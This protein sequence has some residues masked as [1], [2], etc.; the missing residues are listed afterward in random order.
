M[1]EDEYV[2]DAGQWSEPYGVAEGAPTYQPAAQLP[3][4]PLA[5]QP[6]AQP[7]MQARPAPPPL[8]APLMAPTPAYYGAASGFGAPEAPT[9][10][11]HM[12][13]LSL[14]LVGIGAAIG[15]GYGGL[16][17]GV[18]GSMYG[19]A[20]VNAI[21][22]TRHVMRGGAGDDREAAVSGTYAVLGAGVASYLVWR[23]H[24]SAKATVIT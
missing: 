9:E 6:V 13:G 20:T 5:R 15:V 10:G 19:G 14:L 2:E 24:A 23:L 7:V 11:A 18:A 12:L 1:E 16:F 17:G 22:A 3:P 21:R 4:A 8:A